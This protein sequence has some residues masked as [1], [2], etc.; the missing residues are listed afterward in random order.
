MLEQKVW[1][2]CDLLAN[3]LNAETHVRLRLFKLNRKR[4]MPLGA[5]DRLVKIL[6]STELCT[7]G[8]ILPDKA[9]ATGQV[10]VLVA[11]LIG[12]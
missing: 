7:R 10:L 5:V 4:L 12:R 9:P 6:K 2:G 1:A 8:N 11:V 3:E